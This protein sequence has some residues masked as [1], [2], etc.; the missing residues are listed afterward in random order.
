MTDRRS[1]LLERLRGARADVDASRARLRKASAERLAK[2]LERPAKQRLNALAD[3]ALS[4]FDRALLERS[5]EDELPKRRI[6]VPHSWIEDARAIGRSLRFHR[7]AATRI[8]LAVAPAT[9]FVILALLGTP[10]RAIGVSFNVPMTVDWTLPDRSPLHEDLPMGTPSVL[11]ISHGSGYLRK[12]FDGR[13]YGYSG[14][15]PDELIDEH[16]IIRR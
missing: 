10:G 16:H 12:W 5:V 14:P 8:M 4:P 13:G 2:L 11:L 7:R 15:V 3:P 9:C 1:Q 6:V